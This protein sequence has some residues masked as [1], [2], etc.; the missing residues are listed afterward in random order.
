MSKNNH[1]TMACGKLVDGVD[2]DVVG[3]SKSTSLSDGAGVGAAAGG[4]SDISNRSGAGAAWNVKKT[5]FHHFMCFI[6]KKKSH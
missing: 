2:V 5:H 6:Q 1:Q 4:G 3:P